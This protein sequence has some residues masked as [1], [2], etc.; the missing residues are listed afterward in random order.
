MKRSI[1]AIVTTAL[2]I[3]T[4]IAITVSCVP[5]SNGLALQTWEADNTEAN[6][7]E[8]NNPPPGETEDNEPQAG[9]TRAEMVTTVLQTLGLR[10]SAGQDLKPF[11]A[12]LDSFTDVREDDWFHDAFAMAYGLQLIDGTSETQMSPNDLATRELAITV[13]CRLMVLDTATTEAAVLNQFTDSS[14][15]SA[16]ASPYVA[17][18]VAAGYVS[19]TD[20]RLDPQSGVTVQEFERLLHSLFQDNVITDQASADAF[21]GRTVTGNVLITS[22]N[23]TLTDL[24]VTGDVIIGDGVGNGT[25]IL[26]KLTIGGRLVVRGGGTNTIS[27]LSTPVGTVVIKKLSDGSVRIEGDDGSPI[28]F[29]EVPDGSDSIIIECD[30][31]NLSLFG[32]GIDLVVNG[33]VQHVAVCGDGVAISGH[34]T[35]REIELREG[36]GTITVETADT[37]ISN[38]SGT[39]TVVIDKRGTR[40]PLSAGSFVATTGDGSAEVSPRTTAGDDWSYVNYSEDDTRTRHTVTFHSNGGIEMTPLSVIEGHRLGGLPVPAKPNSVFVGWFTDDAT[41]ENEVYAT[42]IAESDL[43]L[44]ACY[45][46][47]EPLAETDGRT[48]TS[49]MDVATDFVITVLSSDTDMTAEEVQSAMTFETVTEEASD[50]GGITVAGSNGTYTVAATDGYT[51]G[52]SYSLTLDSD[53]LTFENE[54]GSVRTFNLTVALAEPVMNVDLRADVQ[55]VPVEDVGEVSQEGQAVDN[56]YA[57]LFTTS[58]EASNGTPSGTFTYTGELSLAVGDRLAVYEGTAPDQRVAGEDYSDETVN[59]VTITAVSEDGRTI[60]YVVADPDEIL[61]IPDLIPVKTSDDVDGSADNLSLTIDT[62]K[63]TFIDPEDFPDFSLDDFGLDATTTIDAGDYIVFYE[64]GEDLEDADAVTFVK[65]SDVE[66]VGDWYV[67]GYEASSEA[68]Y[69]SYMDIS[70]SQELSYDELVENLDLEEVSA[71][72]ERDVLESGFAEAAA[73]YLV[74]LAQADEA[75]QAQICEELGIE[76]FSS[77]IAPSAEPLVA[78]DAPDVDV[79]VRAQITKDLKH[80]TGSGLRCLVSVTCEVELGDHMKLQVTGTFVQEFKVERSL[81]AQKIRKGLKVV[82][83]RV[84]ASLDVYTYTYLSM[85]LGLYS[86]NASGWSD[87]LDIKKTINDL[88]GVVDKATEDTND[89][90]QEFYELYQTMMDVDHGYFPLF[91]VQLCKIEGGIDPLHIF[92]FAFT[93]EFV[94]SLNVDVALGTQ[95]EYEKATRYYFVFSLTKK[96]ADYGTTD[97]IDE[98]YEFT[99]YAMGTLAV[100]VGLKLTLEVGLI[101]TALDSI[102][103]SAEA[104]AYWQV[105]GFLYYHLEYA[106]KQTTTEYAGACYMELG[107]YV[108]IKFQAQALGKLVSYSKELWG[109]SW[110]L[111]SA[112]EQYYT[113]DFGY[114]L[115]DAND[116]IL[117]KAGASSYLVPASALVM[118]QMDFTTGDVADTQ[119]SADKFEF[120]VKNDSGDIFDVESSGLIYVTPPEDSDVATATLQVTWKSAPL[121]FTSAPISRT[122]TLVWDNLKDSYV[123][124]F[125]TNGGNNVAGISGAYQSA[126]TLPTP[127]RSGYTF[128]GWFEDDETFQTPFTETRMPARS[129]TLYAKWTASNVGYAVRHYQQALGS[130]SYTLIEN[131]SL[132]GLA[133]SSV[134]PSLKDYPGFAAP[135]TQ[136]VTLAGDGSTIV[137]Y[138]Y[139]RSSY[140]LTFKPANG[141]ADIVR[142]Y[143]YGT[144]IVAPALVRSGYA[145]AGWDSELA[146]TMPAHALTYTAQWSKN[147]YSISCDLQGGSVSSANPQTYTVDSA[148]ITLTNP[149]KQ[150]FFFAG[151]TG[152]GLTAAT[153]SVTIGTGSTGDRYYSATWKSADKTPYCVQHH[154]EDLSGG[155]TILEIESRTGT[156]GQDTAAVARSYSGF[157]A[158]TVTQQEIAADGTTIVHINYSRNSYTLTF[159]DNGG[160]GGTS[161]NVQY[162]ADISAPTV[163]R[164]GYAFDGWDNAVAGTMPASPTTYTAQW[165]ANAYTVTFDKNSDDATGTMSD[166]DFTYDQQQAIAANAFARTGYTF[167]G[168]NT[169]DEGAG[170]SYDDEEAVS[171]LTAV[172]DGVVTLYAQWVSASGCGVFEAKYSAEYQVFDFIIGSSTI[173]GNAYDSSWGSASWSSGHQFT[174]A[175]L[176]DRY[177]TICK[178]GDDGTPFALYMHESD[179][180]PIVSGTSEDLYANSLIGSESNANLTQACKD[181]LLDLYGADWAEGLAA[182]GAINDMWDEGFMFSSQNGFGYFVSGKQAYTVMGSITLTNHVSN[183]TMAQLDAVSDYEAGPLT[184]A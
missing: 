174:D 129:I 117:L 60:E 167:S 131:E 58:E 93:T 33:N 175:M 28:D 134:T 14:A 54:T 52:C 49:V 1:T 55:L 164:T 138:K 103:V 38:N 126:I 149:T 2:L 152:T 69:L 141:T 135:A 110:P 108:T 112:G 41:F 139:G 166:Q 106:N 94:V 99:V 98:H 113:Y 168:W 125:D 80:W 51:P 59:Y 64:N 56:L 153:T 48:E 84:V 30:V 6:G 155:Y 16:W 183:P 143:Q 19:G 71:E 163:T 176:A 32:D 118:S 21:S 67:I 37:T 42:T 83:R 100:R 63:L 178:T 68:D 82:D 11:M 104:G 91:S 169:D 3:I 145:F 57:P 75:V 89:E 162:G 23:V 97:L 90:V 119:C 29:I 15:L 107:L 140:S 44:Y 150:G 182:T 73:E 147:T 115:T 144:E 127:T 62:D 132:V 133:G 151:W 36:V 154:R 72:V 88:Q 116:D 34:G 123:I 124:S 39:T 160:E 102:G 65:I 79:T 122:F 105:W 50:F 146:A 85:D 35:V 86:K 9:I 53:V 31:S 136:T 17:A 26:D 87:K 27:L 157:T 78:G 142:T 177:F 5:P 61:F 172:D 47:S 181:S 10:A 130:D 121:V 120:L 137:N 4:A 13:L 92:A 45:F 161:E 12:N 179:G 24:T 66:R 25:V 173:N 40:V 171:N 77:A 18:M 158:G 7:P 101:T 8:A 20:G 76:D 81:T 170:T 184:G 22:D 70:V 46:E 156:T 114:E 74:A 111:W 109:D 96:T 180:T 148:A 159:D 95:F 128:N 165:T 43:E